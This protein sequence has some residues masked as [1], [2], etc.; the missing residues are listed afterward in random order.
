[1]QSS[2]SEKEVCSLYNSTDARANHSCFSFTDHAFSATM[3]Y[4]SGPAAEAVESPL[5]MQQPHPAAPQLQ[6]MHA[7]ATC[8][9]KHNQINTC[10]DATEHF[11]KVFAKVFAVVCQNGQWRHAHVSPDCA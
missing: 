9:V 1:M 4:G 8:L 5:G 6:N 7:G 2:S 3:R 10:D 11:G